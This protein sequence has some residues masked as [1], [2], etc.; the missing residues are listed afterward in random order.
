MGTKQYVVRL[1]DGERARLRTLVGSG[2]AAARML[3]HARI[4]LKTD[5]SDG[6]PGWTDAVI[7]AALEVHPATVVRV[8]RQYVVAGLDA[9]LTPKTPTR[10]Y[11]RRLDGA[12]EAHLVA[13]AC[14]TP[15]A[16][17]ARWTLRLLADRL[18]ALE[19]VDAISHET[20]RQT[21]KQT[22]SSRG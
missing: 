3:T 2:A 15:P 16:G 11:R 22:S 18:V 4:L 17:R 12:Q 14:S 5:Q 19:Q 10:E 8:R 13:L 7:A 9:A 1:D 20:V 6:G 21:L